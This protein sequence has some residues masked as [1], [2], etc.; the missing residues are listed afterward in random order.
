MLSLAGFSLQQ[1]TPRRRAS[2]ESTT[3]AGSY[4]V[5]TRRAASTLSSA[6]AQT[7][8]AVRPAV[9]ARA[10]S[11]HAG[12]YARRNPLHFGRP[13]AYASLCRA[14]GLTHDLAETADQCLYRRI[15]D[16]VLVAWHYCTVSGELRMVGI[17]EVTASG[18][19]GPGGGGANGPGGKLLASG[20]ICSGRPWR[21]NFGRCLALS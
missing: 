7:T 20:G 14:R 21:L 6:A 5:R 9:D 11:R 16:I 17:G 10:R 8:E 3:S 1:R 4:I 18:P 12:I 2:E 15:P 19:A 13:R